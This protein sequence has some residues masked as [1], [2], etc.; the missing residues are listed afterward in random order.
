MSYVKEEN[1]EKTLWSVRVESSFRQWAE[2]RMA[3][4]GLDK[5][6]LLTLPVL[7]TPWCF[8]N[9][10]RSS[11]IGG[12]LHYRFIKDHQ[13]LVEHYTQLANKTATGI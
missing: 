8:R 2:K 12:E 1:R 5:A 9:S 10:P 11:A 3:H 13:T 4:R 7:R 6:P